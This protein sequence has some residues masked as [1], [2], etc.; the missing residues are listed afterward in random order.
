MHFCCRCDNYCDCNAEF[1]CIMCSRCR[2]D[3]EYD[4]ND[5]EYDDWWE[6]D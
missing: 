1:S 5:F 2:I 3:D 6:E 4:F